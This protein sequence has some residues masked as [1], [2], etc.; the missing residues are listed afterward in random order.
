MAAFC[1]A[2]VPLVSGSQSDRLGSVTGRVIDGI[3]GRPIPGARVQHVAPMTGPTVGPPPPLPSQQADAQG[4]FTFRGL[5]PGRHRFMANAGGYLDSPDG[6]PRPSLF[7]DI[8]GAAPKT[9]EIRLWPAGLIRGR[10]VHRTTGEPLVGVAVNAVNLGATLTARSYFEMTDDRGEYVIRDLPAGQFA[11]GVPFAAYTVV[12]LSARSSRP[13]PAG[14]RGRIGSSVVQ[15]GPHSLS[16]ARSRG[17]VSAV[18]EVAGNRVRL[19]R[20]VF[21]NGAT[22]LV[23]A[24]PVAVGIGDERAGIDL[25][26][27]TVD[28]RRVSGVVIDPAGASVEGTPVRLYDAAAGESRL[29]RSFAVAHTS[30]TASGRFD[31]LGVASGAYI[32]DVLAAD[33]AARGRGPSAGSGGGVRQ[34]EA[35][36]IVSDRD[37]EGVELR[38]RPGPR[39]RGRIVSDGPRLTPDEMRS[40]RVFLQLV[41]SPRLGRRAGTGATMQPQADVS[42]D[43]TV[44]AGPLVP[45]DYFFRVQIPGYELGWIR[46]QGRL[47]TA[48]TFRIRSDFT[49]AEFVV[50]KQLGQLQGTV[51]APDW[52][53]AGVV[54][55]A[56]PADRSSWADA[57]ADMMRVKQIGLL[58][59]EPFTVRSLPPG[60][61]LVAVS[62]FGALPADWRALA[63]LQALAGRAVRVTIPPGGSATV[64]VPLG[65]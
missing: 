62:A 51:E 20:P 31:L 40:A 17:A 63:S 24:A 13:M 16:V 48:R 38:L 47:V 44:S 10:V 21:W 30:V 29:T 12:D 18:A 36:V 52:P 7:V 28:A 46:Y 23:S 61:Y 8:E 3:T 6:Q 9:V 65:R 55:T 64:R 37:V 57:R 35:T 14:V 59:R 49:G 27:D 60:E 45:G 33:A 58:D 41:E 34:A 5:V 53:A 42:S 1:T 39:V 11:V 50:T 43:G 32:V 26:V 2:D 56:F 4:R 15:I 54:V 19:H 22:T 25:I